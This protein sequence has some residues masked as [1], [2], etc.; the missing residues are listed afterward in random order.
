MSYTFLKS[1]GIPVGRSLVEE[2]KIHTAKR[3]LE[4][5]QT[6]NIHIMLPLDHVIAQACEASA[7][8]VTTDGTEIPDDMMGLDIGPKT[9]AEY[10]SEVMKAKTIFWNGPMGVFEIPEFA[11]GTN[12]IAVAVAE[13]NANSVVGGGDSVAAINKAGVADRIGHISTG[14]GASLEFVEGK[15]LPGLMALES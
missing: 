4:R 2:D 9:T 8:A 5:A 7:K 11:N 15:K 6:R 10:A 1:Q 14:G 13:S 12:S 3:I